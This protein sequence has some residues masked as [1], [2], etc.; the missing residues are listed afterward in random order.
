[1]IAP[2]AVSVVIPACNAA[3]TLSETLD[4]LIAQRFA[5]WEAIVVDDGSDDD[6][7]AV[8]AAYA[9]RDARIR[10]IRQSRSGVCAARNA[11]IATCLHDWLLF[12][13]ADDWVT[14]DHLLRMTDRLHTSPEIDAV[15]CGWVRVAPNGARVGE[16]LGPDD[17]D[18][19]RC[20]P[21]TVHSR[22]MRASFARRP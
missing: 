18:L 15:H 20:S 17:V 11:G 21:A 13:D 19:F 9:E 16:K 12:L 14:P 2:L 5:D 1:M 10:L 22:S 3:A 6:T 8:A 4:S 7:A